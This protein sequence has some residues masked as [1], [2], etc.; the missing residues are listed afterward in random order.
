[1]YCRVVKDVDRRFRG[2]Y[3]LHHQGDAVHFTNFVFKGLNLE[4]LSGQL[5][6]EIIIPKNLT[7]KFGFPAADG[8]SDTRAAMPARKTVNCS[9]TRWRGSWNAD[10]TTRNGLSEPMK[11]VVARP[12]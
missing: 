4:I 5:E 2:A 1:V 6:K 3:C 9:M 10:V 11:G 12:T 8:S 7:P